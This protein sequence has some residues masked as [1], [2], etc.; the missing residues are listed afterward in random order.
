[1]LKI[2]LNALPV[3]CRTS[4]K[5]C[6]VYVRN[7]RNEGKQMTELEIGKMVAG[8]VQQNISSIVELGGNFVSGAKREVRVRLEST[9]KAYLEETA[10]R[11]SKTKSFFIRNSSVGLYDFYVP[12]SVRS[13][14]TRI[15]N[16]SYYNL[17]RKSNR[18]VVLGTGGSGKSVLMKHL[19]IGCISTKEQVPVFVELR[20]LNSDPSSLI[21]LIGRSLNSDNYNFDNEFI[22]K[23]IKKG[24]YAFIFDGYDEVRNSLRR[25]LISDL[26]SLSRKGPKCSIFI[27]SR[28]DEVFSGIEEFDI[29]RV[30]SL[31]LES[32]CSLVN[33]LPFDEDIKEKFVSELNAGMYEKHESFLSNP[34]LLSIMLLTYGQNA[35]IP[36]KLSI[37]YSQAYEALFH[38]HDALKGGYKRERCTTLDIQDFAKVFSVFSLQT[39]DKRLFDLSKVDALSHIDRSKRHLSMSFENEDFL[40]DALKATCLLVEDGLRIVFSHRS[41]QEYFVAFYI[42]NAPPEIQNKLLMKYW[43]NMRSDSVIALTYEMNKDLVERILLVP[44]LKE[45]FDRIDVKKSVGITHITKFIKLNYSSINI[46]EES[47][48]ATCRSN[49]ADY[50]DVLHFALSITKPYKAP[51]GVYLKDEVNFLCSRYGKSE[52]REEYKTKDLSYRNPLIRDL[53][54]GHGIFSIDYLAEGFEA[55]KSL[56]EKHNKTERTLAELLGV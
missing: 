50:S 16:P 6:P 10:T 20:D 31:T 17:T 47:L 19:F 13:G 22:E 12:I 15:D 14:K 54:G 44:L 45:L 51:E 55:F 9:Y 30:E 23:A 34:L 2:I 48:S 7:N 40:E 39:Y 25:K 38:R 46:A 1:V 24:H 33:K 21:E 27:S 5:A 28:P 41:F 42:N 56:Q 3:G 36:T 43:K 37:F 11:Y 53:A 29:F 35:E 26:R 8:F 32:A 52:G 49:N 4:K 18:T